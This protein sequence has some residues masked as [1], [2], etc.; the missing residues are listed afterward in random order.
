[1]DRY[2]RF[3]K[4]ADEYGEELTEQIEN[5]QNNVDD[6]LSKAG[7]AHH[8]MMRC[9]ERYETLSARAT[10]CAGIDYA[11]MGRYG[12]KI[13][14]SH[15][16]SIEDV[17]CDLY[18]AEVDYQNARIAYEDARFELI[19][20]IETAGLTDKQQRVMY[21]RYA[22]GTYPDFN[23]IARR[24]GLASYWAACKQ[25]E[26]GFVKIATYLRGQGRA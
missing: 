9:L 3:S 4:Y 8:K 7:D 17:Y 16:N 22:D 18:D 23:I 24:C 25:Y 21:L 26:R 1:M 6:V 5:W 15:N 2:V 14:S 12:V 10:S 11:R 19:D 20:L 13:T